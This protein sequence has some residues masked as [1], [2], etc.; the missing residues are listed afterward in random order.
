MDLFAVVILE[1]KNICPTSPLKVI[2]HSRGAIQ[3][4]NYVLLPRSAFLKSHFVWRICDDYSMV[5]EKVIALDM[6]S[7]TVGDECRRCAVQL[8]VKSSHALN[9]ASQVTI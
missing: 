8:E 4:G 7:G 2:H 3:A 6:L 5:S 1:K 9:G